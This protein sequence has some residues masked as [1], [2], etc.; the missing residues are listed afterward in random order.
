[1]CDYDA[2]VIKMRGAEV[3][4]GLALCHVGDHQVK[5]FGRPGDGNQATCLPFGARLTVM[6]PKLGDRNATFGINE[7]GSW[8]DGLVF[9]DNGETVRLKD[10]PLGT[11]ATVFVL[12]SLD[13]PLS[14]ADDGLAKAA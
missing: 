11:A 9:A 6:D 7:N 8:R 5:G 4:D 10:L 1:M 3:G 13:Q 14:N 12:P 2:G